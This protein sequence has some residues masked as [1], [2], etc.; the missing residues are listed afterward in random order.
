MAN[1][2]FLE[3]INIILQSVEK[4]SYSKDS[5][6]STEDLIG[7]FPELSFLEH[8][9]QLPCSNQTYFDAKSVE[10]LD[11]HLENFDHILT[12]S[13][14]GSVIGFVLMEDSNVVT[15]TGH[16]TALHMTGIC[17]NY[18]FKVDATILDFVDVFAMT[19]GVKNVFVHMQKDKDFWTK[20]EVYINK[21]YT[22][23]SSGDKFV[24]NGRLGVLRKCL[25]TSSIVAG[26]TKET[27]IRKRDRIRNM[28]SRR[29]KTQTA[30]G[31]EDL[32]P[33]RE[34]T[35]GTFHR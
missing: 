15:P 11:S 5:T 30:V 20:S 19:M 2:R 34:S 17:A 32:F 28:F 8:R 33:D 31:I 25:E 22:D 13:V 26:M 3:N 9:S 16:H 23:E 29:R 12:V 18:G 4:K 35:G 21:G 10:K 7:R 6:E 24:I 1:T 27:S 14:K